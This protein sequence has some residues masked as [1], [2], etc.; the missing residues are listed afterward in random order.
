MYRDNSLFSL[1]NLTPQGGQLHMYILAF[2]MFINI[3]T[4]IVFI[5]YNKGPSSILFD[6]LFSSLN[7]ISWTSFQ[8]LL[9][10]NLI[11]FN[12]HMAIHRMD[13]LSFCYAFPY[14]RAVH[15]VFTF[16]FFLP[17][18][19]CYNRIF[20]TLSLVICK[21]RFLEVGL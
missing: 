7:N 10:S 18:K 13:L 2:S 9:Y 15:I 8:G 1:S 21:I 17:F 20:I 3:Y 6:I 12:N 14:D 19:Q 16:F 5:S 11:L 4:Y